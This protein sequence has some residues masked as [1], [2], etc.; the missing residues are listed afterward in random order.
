MDNGIRILHRQSLWINTSNQ[1]TLRYQYG[2]LSQGQTTTSNH[3]RHDK[4]K[5]SQDK[6]MNSDKR[7]RVE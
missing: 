5:R 6:T 7:K 3:K 2:F 4:N 1:L